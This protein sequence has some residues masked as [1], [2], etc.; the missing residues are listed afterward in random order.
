MLPMPITCGFHPLWNLALCLL[1][2]INV[3]MGSKKCLLDPMN[4]QELRI[5]MIQEH[6]SPNSSPLHTCSIHLYYRVWHMTGRKKVYKWQLHL[7]ICH[8]KREQPLFWDSSQNSQGRRWPCL[9]RM[10]ISWSTNGGQ[11]LERCSDRNMCSSFLQSTITWGKCHTA[12]WPI[13]ATHP[14]LAEVK[15]KENY[16]KTRGWDNN[17]KHVYHK[18][19]KGNHY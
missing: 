11:N 17:Y 13:G 5:R 3:L 2:V 4:G 19:H 15:G 16:Q 6:L 18:S 12:K 1:S 7:C 10:P 9:G 14:P 8:P